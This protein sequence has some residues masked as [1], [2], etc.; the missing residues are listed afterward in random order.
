MHQHIHPVIRPASSASE[1]SWWRSSQF[2]VPFGP[3]M[4][5]AARGFAL[6]R[7]EEHGDV[8][9]PLEQQHPLSNSARCA[10]PIAQL[11][12]AASWRLLASI[13]R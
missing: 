5:S 8:L 7:K 12:A 13:D 11:P 10:Q 4:E 6:C 2:W 1:P 9:S 3:G